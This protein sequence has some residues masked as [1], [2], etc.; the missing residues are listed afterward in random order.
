[1]LVHSSA[2]ALALG[3]S[4]SPLFGVSSHSP[5]QSFQLASEEDTSGPAGAV[6]GSSPG[7]HTSVLSR[8]SALQF[9]QDC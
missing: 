3:P 7:G 2:Q 9:P 8:G 5:S 4:A 6:A 1:M